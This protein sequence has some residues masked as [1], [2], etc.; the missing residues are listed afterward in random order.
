MIRKL[1][2]A[3]EIGYRSRSANSCTSPILGPGCPRKFLGDNDTNELLINGHR[4]QN[5]VMKAGASVLDR[6]SYG[7][8]GGHPDL[9]CQP[10]ADPSIGKEIRTK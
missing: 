4:Q 8:P 5:I 2:L 6:V 9:V 7:L 1:H 10:R 3:G